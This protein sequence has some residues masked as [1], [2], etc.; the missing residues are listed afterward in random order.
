MASSR[1][2][3]GLDMGH[4]AVKAVLATANGK[5]LRVLKAEWVPI[6][7]DLPDP[8]GPLRKWVQEQKLGN[9]PVSL[10]IGGSRVLYQTIRME[11]EDPRRPEQIAAM[12]AMR[13]RDI[14]DANMVAT[15]TPAS[16][17]PK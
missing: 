1:N 7:Q 5:R 11:A 14:T 3:L 13:F 2:V 15:A 8:S 10:C 4:H 16:A 9:T 17:D 6:P 12:E